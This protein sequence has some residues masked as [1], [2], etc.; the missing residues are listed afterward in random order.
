MRAESKYVVF[1]GGECV[2]VCE[3]VLQG[4]SGDLPPHPPSLIS[5]GQGLPVNLELGGVQQAPVSFLF[6]ACMHG[7]SQV[8]FFFLGFC[9]LVVWV[10]GYFV[11]LFLFL[12]IDSGIE[13]RSSFL[14]RKHSYPQSQLPSP[15]PQTF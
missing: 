8:F 15:L 10:S 5:L 12:F 4:L 11:C 14:Y 6:P 1:V 2:P 13:L 7:H 3:G 9:W